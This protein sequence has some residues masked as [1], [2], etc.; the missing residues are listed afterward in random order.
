M[1]LE[2]VVL[3]CFRPL[4][5]SLTSLLSR[6][7]FI[8]GSGRVARPLLALAGGGGF[9]YW[10]GPLQREGRFSL[11]FTDE[12]RHRGRQ[13]PQRCGLAAAWSTQLL[14]AGEHRVRAVPIRVLP[15]DGLQGFGR[16]S[17]GLPDVCR[18][19]ART[20][21]SLNSGCLPRQTAGALIVTL[22][23][24]IQ[25]TASA[26]KHARAPSR[27]GTNGGAQA[28]TCNAPSPS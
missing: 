15:Q 27:P 22:L 6:P 26:L 16:T 8:Q 25:G 23:V 5:L 24:T 4:S 12:A 2:K 14:M 11:L 21:M 20:S 17:V 7:V 10:R 19:S 18:F 13:A 28:A 3:R 1:S 9:S